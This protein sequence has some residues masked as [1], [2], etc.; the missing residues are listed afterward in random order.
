MDGHLILRQRERPCDPCILDIIVQTL[1]KFC[2]VLGRIQYTFILQYL[3]IC[4]TSKRKFFNHWSPNYT[5]PPSFEKASQLTLPI[6]KEERAANDISN[7]N[8]AREIDIG[9]RE[10]EKLS[11]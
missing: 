3:S 11:I 7:S 10:F 5:F 1:V 6:Q 8:R 4:L 2:S 9:D